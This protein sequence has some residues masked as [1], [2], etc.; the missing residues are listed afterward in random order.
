M[1]IGWKCLG[2]PL[3]Q[4]ADWIFRKR[5]EAPSEAVANY[6]K[7]CAVA[8]VGLMAKDGRGYRLVCPEEKGGEP[9]L[10]D[11]GQWVGYDAVET[12]GKPQ[13]MIHW[14][15]FIYMQARRTLYRRQLE[16]LEDGNA[17]LASNFDALIL[18]R[19][20]RLPLG[21]DLGMW[22]EKALTNVHIDARRR[23]VSEEKIILPG[24]PHA[25]AKAVAQAIRE[26]AEGEAADW[27]Y[28]DAIRRYG[29]VGGR[30]PPTRDD[31]PIEVGVRGGMERVRPFEG[32][33]ILAPG[34]G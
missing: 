31:K 24:I 29:R 5:R 9:V 8:F 13:G 27:R 34:G 1:G 21:S 22:R 4:W 32:I 18:L 7:R 25:D 3:K 14:A 28:R 2:T 11:R 10:N 17:V 6:V 33:R 30:A 12:V 15:S 26:R 19:P 16:E 20:S 23:L